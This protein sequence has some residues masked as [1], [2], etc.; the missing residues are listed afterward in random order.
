MMSR[1]FSFP[2]GESHPTR[3]R[4]GARLWAMPI[5]KKT[6]LDEYIAA[7]NAKQAQKT[8]QQLALERR[9]D[10]K[11]SDD[12]LADAMKRSRVD[13]SHIPGRSRAQEDERSILKRKEAAAAAA[14][15][16]A[17]ARLDW[18]E[19]NEYGHIIM[20]SNTRCLELS[21]V[22]D[23]TGANKA[24]PSYTRG[25]Q[26]EGLNLVVENIEMSNSTTFKIL[27]PRRKAQYNPNESVRYALA[28]GAHK[29]KPF[30]L[31]EPLEERVMANPSTGQIEAAHLHLNS[32]VLQDDDVFKIGRAML[33]SKGVELLDLY[34]NFISESPCTFLADGINAAITDGDCKLKSLSLSGNMPGPALYTSLQDTIKT[35]QTLTSLALTNLFMPMTDSDGAVLCKG[36]GR[37]RSL[38]HLDLSGNLLG[39]L[40]CWELR[41]GVIAN[42]TLQTLNLECNL[43]KDDGCFQL[44]GAMSKN[45]DN[46]IHSLWLGWNHIDHVG[47]G[48]LIDCAGRKHA[49]LKLLSLTNNKISRCS[50]GN[51]IGGLARTTCL[52]SLNLAYNRIADMSEIGIG[53]YINASLLD[54]DLS[55]NYLADDAFAWFAEWGKD[56]QATV[57]NRIRSLDLRH[58]KLGDLAGQQICKGLMRRKH[59]RCITRIVLSD[60]LMDP[61]ICQAAEALT[62]KMKP[63]VLVRRE[64]KLLLKQKLGEDKSYWKER[65]WEALQKKRRAKM[66]E[67]VRLLNN[68][69][70][71]CCVCAVMHVLVCV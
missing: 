23:Y 31:V 41:L 68:R 58:N 32:V 40:T 62:N 3:S 20:S 53:L 71:E 7:R 49:K 47:F 54:L 66:D 43:I 22:P 17:S 11:V 10:P 39:T 33:H 48:A 12:S 13:L 61:L 16:M 14:E 42:T 15:R 69:T 64:A 57:R 70:G 30:E 34:G 5:N 44:A 60:N 67:A 24:G 26:I 37:S 25:Q 56:K 18:T 1:A 51:V 29:S 46:S 8:V 28:E 50:S 21:S 55:Y 36:L 2:I 27:K 59:N 35:S 9:G 45:P 19:T 52:T 38:Q 63:F 65:D 6:A 4:A